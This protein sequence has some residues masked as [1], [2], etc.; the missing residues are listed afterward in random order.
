MIGIHSLP[1]ETL[2]H[3]FRLFFIED[4]DFIWDFE[5]VYCDILEANRALEETMLV[6]KHWYFAA[7]SFPRLWTRIPVSWPMGVAALETRLRRSAPLPVKIYMTSSDLNLLRLLNNYAARLQEFH[8]NTDYNLTDDEA[9]DG[10]EI[11]VN[12][13][14]L[15]ER[16]SFVWYYRFHWGDTLDGLFGGVMPR[17][18]KLCIY[19]CE[20]FPQDQ[21][22][23]LTRLHLIR[24][25]DQGT[26][27]LP[28]LL[29]TLR[30]NPTLEELI[31][32]A[33]VPANCPGH[34]EGSFLDCVPLPK[35]RILHLTYYWPEDIHLFC[36][37]VLPR[38]VHTVIQELPIEGTSS[39]I[40]RYLP[41][42][43]NM[44]KR[45]YVVA[46]MSISYCD[47][48]WDMLGIES[49]AERG[50]GSAFRF[51]CRL[52]PR[53]CRF[54]S[55]LLMGTL[56]LDRLSELWFESYMADAEKIF[57]ER[58]WVAVLAAAPS[59]HTICVRGCVTIPI[60]TALIYRSN[61][62][63][64]PVPCPLLQTVKIYDEPRISSTALN[65]FT[66]YR[67]QVGYPIS[68]LEISFKTDAESVPQ[69][70]DVQACVGSILSLGVI[71]RADIRY[72]VEMDDRPR[73]CPPPICTR[74]SEHGQDFAPHP[75]PDKPT[76]TIRLHH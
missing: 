12:P 32:W 43:F 62:N 63:V 29:D 14:P 70:G 3:I 25:A 57:E 75:P 20:P 37:M 5:R 53:S 8:V 61:E 1:L 13:A 52:S 35:L 60:L 31:L 47:S 65:I 17:L 28:E 36:H 22:R 49:S 55:V 4:D 21:F 7:K 38:G 27:T 58:M 24:Q 41:M 16:L 40:E 76:C 10:V 46:K 18:T 64:A 71:R 68:E 2:T 30:A 44:W 67:H 45:L 72:A 73:V 51:R 11:M 74:G 48:V 69:Q 26:Y 15:L 33:A 59:L 42:I 56:G 34:R 9:A 50:G 23:N 19:P 66:M 39:G 6:C 54:F